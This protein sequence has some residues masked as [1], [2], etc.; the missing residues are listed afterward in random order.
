[1]TTGDSVNGRGV[2]VDDRRYV[3]KEEFSWL[4]IWYKKGPDRSPYEVTRQPASAS[5]MSCEG[6]DPLAALQNDL[7]IG[8][9]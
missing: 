7:Q 6:A 3:P 8:N 9:F 2:E 1:M 5:E 4:V